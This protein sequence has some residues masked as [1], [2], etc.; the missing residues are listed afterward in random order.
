MTMTVAAA[1]SRDLERRVCGEYAEMPGHRLTLAQA[2]RLWNVDADASATVL[3]HLVE[4]GFLRR[5]GPYYFRTDL[6]HATA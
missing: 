4:S 5:V 2:C 3:D 1:T 6:G